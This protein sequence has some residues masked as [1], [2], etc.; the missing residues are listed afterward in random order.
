ME[1][2]ELLLLGR[3]T[4]A[5]ERARG[6]RGLGMSAL[7]LPMVILSLRGCGPAW[8]SMSLGA[9]LALVVALFEYRGGTASRAVI[10][11]LFAGVAPLVVPFVVC[12]LLRRAGLTS[13]ALIAACMAG[14]VFSGAIVTFFA[15]RETDHRLRFIFAA[16]SMAALAGSLGCLDVGLGG[17]VAMLAGLAT[18]APVGLRAALR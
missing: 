9:L 7:V 10:P 16:G 18:L 11:G 2:N 3:A 12:P 1:P 17:I 6:V 5:Y 13:P 8:I 15:L 14:G 4:R